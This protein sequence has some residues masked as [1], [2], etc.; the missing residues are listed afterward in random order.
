MCM[1][2]WSRMG[3]TL[4]PRFI[5]MWSKSSLY[6]NF[7]L[8]LICIP[9]HSLYN[10]KDKICKFRNVECLEIA[11]WR[12]RLIQQYPLC[13][14]IQKKK[15]KKQFVNKKWINKRGLEKPH[16]KKS[17]NLTV[18]KHSFNT[19]EQKESLWSSDF[20][21]T[22]GSGLLEISSGN[23]TL[24]TLLRATCLAPQIFLANNLS[25]LRPRSIFIHLLVC[26]KTPLKCTN[27]G[28]FQ[29]FNE[30]SGYLKLALYEIFQTLLSKSNTKNKF[31]KT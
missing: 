26:Q 30:P 11:I 14:Y 25:H 6:S 10:R 27:V 5:H 23:K 8:R 7:A 28:L 19:S 17:L 1:G 16:V 20:N 15:G 4:V 31:I 22:G 3:L 21:R 29:F 13:F 24:K 18:W 9:Q 2:Y 12:L